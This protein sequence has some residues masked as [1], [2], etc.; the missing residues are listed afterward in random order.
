MRWE[1]WVHEGF[2]VGP[3]PLRECGVDV[4]VIVC[5]LL[6]ERAGGRK[7]VVEAGF[8]PF[9]FVCI[10]WDIIARSGRQ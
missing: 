4:P 9:D 6:L 1:V 2:V 5:G 8:E 3:V 7:A 10:V